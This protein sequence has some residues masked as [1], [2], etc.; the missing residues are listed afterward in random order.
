MVNTE[1][2]L[3]IFFLAKDGEALYNQK[4]TGP[5]ADCGSDHQLLIAKFRFKLKKVGKTTR[6]ARYNLN[7]IPY[8]YIV[9]VMNRVEELYLVNKVPE[10]LWTE[11]CD[12]VEEIPKKKKNKKAKWMFVEALQIAEEREMKSKG[13][14]ERH[15]QLNAVFQRISRRDKKA[16]LYE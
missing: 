7:Q 15:T 6:P 12:T 5:G 2:R 11:V 14:R 10:E 9:E 3:I 16:F 8:E 13:E 4:K 1:I